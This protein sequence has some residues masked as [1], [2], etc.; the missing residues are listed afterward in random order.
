MRR[1]FT[2]VELLVVIAIIG[3]LVAL[4]LPAVQA[5]REAARRTQCAA[6]MKQLGLAHHNYHS[7][8]GQLPPGFIS[9]RQTPCGGPGYDGYCAFNDPELPY[10]AH[11]FPYLGAQVLYDLIDFNV[12]WKRHTWGDAASGTVIETIICPSDGNGLMI[13]PKHSLPSFPNP[14]IS[15][16]NYLALFNG[17]RLADIANERRP[18][19][20]A[21]FGINRGAR[22]AEILD[23]TS[24]TMLM[25]EYLRGTPGSDDARGMFW[26]FQAGGGCLFTRYTPNSS[27]LDILV[28]DENWCSSR[29]GHHRPEMNLP[30]RKSTSPGWGD[31]TAASR[32]LH[33]GGVNILLADGGVRFIHE[34]IDVKTW[35]WLATIAGE[36]TID[37]SDR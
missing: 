30:C 32:S 1:G 14:Q 2:L 19:T 27:S 6:N 13:L 24:K 21:A 35:R 36:E 16:G 34:N 15:K 4:L 5:A 23:G 17:S 18:S 25:A 3:I 8:A 12:S 33:P 28:S 31:T 9:N 29:R 37:A 10:M 22:F 11:L 20:Q 7:S 26:T